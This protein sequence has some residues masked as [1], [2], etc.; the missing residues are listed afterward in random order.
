MHLAPR[1]ATLAALAAT[2]VLAACGGGD[3]DDS[4]SG[5][6]A[7]TLT[8][9][10]AT[11]AANTT[12][13]D[14]ATATSRGNQARAADAFSSQPYCEVFFENASGAN[15][16]KYALQVYFRQSDKLPLHVSVVGANGY[17][18]FNNAAGAP[19]TGITVDTGARTLGF[20]NKV[21][22]GS[23][24][25]AGTLSGSVSFPANSGTPACGA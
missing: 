2:V 8:I 12:T 1:P 16:V 18:V 9:A 15:G 19:I 11:P 22:A 14:L 4:R 3:D 13:V 24:G 21:L 23:G 20:A 17:V 6:G 7:G 25:E 5:A 10:A